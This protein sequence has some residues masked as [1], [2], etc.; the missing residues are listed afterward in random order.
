MCDCVCV[1][2]ESTNG[3][4]A[5]FIS[6]R[7]LSRIHICFLISLVRTLRSI[8]SPPFRL[9]CLLVYYRYLS[10]RLF[11]KKKKKKKILLRL[12]IFVQILWSTHICY[13]HFG[14]STPGPSGW[15][16]DFCQLKR[17]KKN[18]ARVII[19][20]GTM[21]LKPMNIFPIRHWTSNRSM[22]HGFFAAQFLYLHTI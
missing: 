4:E 12:F 17:E 13:R 2:T 7:D 11:K 21:A 18:R 16:S 1:W 19:R 10:F 14:R 3:P 9:L 15:L 8:Q 6:H 22:S 20:N 5:I